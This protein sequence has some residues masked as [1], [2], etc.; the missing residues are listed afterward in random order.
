MEKLKAY[1]ALNKVYENFTDRKF[2]L[3]WQEYV[4]QTIKRN[5][6]GISGADVA[7]GSGIFTRAMRAAGFNVIGIDSSEEMLSKAMEKGGAEYVLQDMRRLKLFKKVDFITVIND[8]INYIPGNELEKVFSAFRRNLVK[9]GFLM[10]DLSSKYKLEEI[11][12][13]NMFGEADDEYAYMW[14]NKL[15]EGYVDMDLTVFCRKGELFERKDESQRQ[16]IHTE[17][18]I[19]T[20]LIN[21]GFNLIGTEGLF[22][23]ALDEKSER[24]TFLARC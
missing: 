2:S 20:A 17:D 16:F 5:S 24:I 7:C 8:G 10:F 23:A 13:N 4:I 11:I 15:G 9:G 6:P 18:G 22:G 21:S 1:D 19:R 14:F 12:G 3:K